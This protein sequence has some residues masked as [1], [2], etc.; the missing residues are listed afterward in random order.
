MMRFNP[1]LEEVED[2]KIRYQAGRVGDVEVKQK[3]ALLL[4]C[5]A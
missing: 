5:D 4:K 3:L 1:N 2:L